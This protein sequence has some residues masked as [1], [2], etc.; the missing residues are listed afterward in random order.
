MATTFTLDT[1]LFEEECLARFAG[2]QSDPNRDGALYRIEREE[3]LAALLCAAVV[4]DIHHCAG[5]RSLRWDLLASRPESGV[6]HAKISLLAWQRHVRAIVASANLTTD[7]YRRNQECAAVLDFDLSF[8]DR[9]LLDPLLEYLREILDTT[10]TGQ[11]RERAQQL[12]EWVDGHLP[13]NEASARGLQ[14]RLVLVGPGARTPSTSSIRTCLRRGRKQRTSYR[15]SSTRRRV[16]RGRRS[17]CGRC[18][19]SAA[20]QNCSST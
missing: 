18:C 11:T 10:A 4:A 6:M 13:R 8:A 5:R 17:G 2:V 1:A 20:M 14:R 7:G 12:L 9:G 19:G 3:K 16:P 15:H